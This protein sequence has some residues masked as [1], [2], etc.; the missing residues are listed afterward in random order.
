MHEIKCI[1]QE[2]IYMIMISYFWVKNSL[3]CKINVKQKQ[4]ENKTN[5]IKSVKKH[6]KTTISKN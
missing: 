1:I 6:K 2:H 3:I 4:K 5:R